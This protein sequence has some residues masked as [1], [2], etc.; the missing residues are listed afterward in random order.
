MRNCFKTNLA[1][2]EIR[3]DQSG[4]DNFRVTYGKQVDS[5]L[6]YTRAAST[7]GESIMHALTCEGEL[8]NRTIGEALREYRKR[9]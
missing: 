3:L 2:F 1:G 5:G 9:G 6:S 4:P 7:L 8:D